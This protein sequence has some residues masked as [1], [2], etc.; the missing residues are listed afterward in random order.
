M[1]RTTSY[2]WLVGML[3]CTGMHGVGGHEDQQ[4]S[5]AKPERLGQVR[6]EVS[7]NASA[8]AEFNRGMALF[9]SF[10]FNPA[11]SSFHKVLEA[12]PGCG[13][14]DWGIAFMSMGNPFAWPANPKAM[15]AAAA[16]MT[17]AERV[18]AKTQRERDYIAALGTFFKDWETADH[19]TRAVALQQAIEALAARYS[20]DDEA[21]ILY[22]LVLDATALPTD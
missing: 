21:Q 3:L 10:W 12:D 1:R 4:T 14:A 15:Q 13:M 7:C 16:A 19:R 17:D 18:G 20:Q 5:G 8:Q 22:A 9:H 6:F 2:S 11:I